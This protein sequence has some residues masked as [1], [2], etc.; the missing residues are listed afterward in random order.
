MLGKPFN[1][2]KRIDGFDLGRLFEG[3]SH[4]LQQRSLYLTLDF[5]SG[6]FYIPNNSFIFDS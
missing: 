6:K 2:Q 1:F 4:F 5:A 3:D